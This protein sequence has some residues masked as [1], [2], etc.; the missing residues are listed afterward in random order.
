MDLGRAL[1]DR[2]REMGHQ[3]NCFMLVCAR[4]DGVHLGP[5]GERLVAVVADDGRSEDGV[6]QVRL[7]AEAAVHGLDGD[8]GLGGDGV[9][10]G[11]PVPEFCEQL[12]RGRDDAPSSLFGSLSSTGAG[13][14]ALDNHVNTVALY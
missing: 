3:A 8:V 7:V 12:C 6:E 4:P 14:G 9:D 10:G 2:P 5:V 13:R 1:E 11:R